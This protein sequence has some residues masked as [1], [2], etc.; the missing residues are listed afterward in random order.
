MSKPGE[1]KHYFWNVLRWLYVLM[2]G[3]ILAF[4]SG[5]LTNASY[6]AFP[7]ERLAKFSQT[8]ERTGEIHLA[9]L[10]SMMTLEVMLITQRHRIA[11]WAPQARGACFAL[12]GVALFMLLDDFTLAPIA[13]WTLFAYRMAI[14]DNLDT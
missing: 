14:I 7:P 6:R 12:Q 8:F 5:L 10:V 13:L 9:F 4:A 3:Y 1:P 11:E 2:Y